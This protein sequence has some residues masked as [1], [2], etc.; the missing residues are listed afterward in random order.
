MLVNNIS[1][2]KNMIIDCLLNFFKIISDNLNPT[3]EPSPL[4]MLKTIA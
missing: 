1:A 2:T 3:D 4:D